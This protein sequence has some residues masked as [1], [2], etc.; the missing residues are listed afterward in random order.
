MFRPAPPSVDPIPTRDSLPGYGGG[1]REARNVGGMTRRFS[2]VRSRLRRRSLDPVPLM[3]RPVG[4]DRPEAGLGTT[5]CQP[6]TQAIPFL[7]LDSSP[8]RAGKA[9]RLFHEIRALHRCP[10]CPRTNIRSCDAPLP[11]SA[12][13]SLSS[14]SRETRRL[15]P[16]APSRSP[17]CRAATNADR[18]A[19]RPSPRKFASRRSRN[20]ARPPC[21]WGECTAKAIPAPVLARSLRPR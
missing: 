8:A 14:S 15:V 3:N 2:Y 17:C 12:A 16:A 19:S 4:E 21:G 10:P 6:T 9:S 1:F 11:P 13:P 7:P 5:S 20:A 18:R